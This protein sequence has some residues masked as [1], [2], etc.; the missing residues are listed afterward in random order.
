MARKSYYRRIYMK[1]RYYIMA[2]LVG[3]TIGCSQVD[4]WYDSVN[5]NDNVDP[6]PTATP[7]PVPTAAPTPKPTATPKPTSAPTPKPTA[8]PTAGPVDPNVP[9]C[10]KIIPMVSLSTGSQKPVLFKPKSQD[11][12]DAR[13]GKG[14]L[15]L[16]GHKWG[17]KSGV[18]IFNAGGSEVGKLGY[19]GDYEKVGERYYVG[20]RG[21]SGETPEQLKADG[22]KY[23]E[24]KNSGEC[25]GPF[26]P[27]Q[28]FGGNK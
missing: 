22:A 11:T 28:R 26:D 24:G 6:K 10:S 14:A 15:I 21:G 3:L 17:K 9:N 7:S 1:L 4:K 23:I 20:Y 8:A 25:Y 13:E 12:H 5:H 27:T 19:Y 16:I 18:R 2:L